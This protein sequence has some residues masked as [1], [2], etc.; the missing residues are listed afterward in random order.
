MRCNGGVGAEIGKHDVRV[1]AEAVRRRRDLR[2]LARCEGKPQHA[3]SEAQRKES[4]FK[5]I[6]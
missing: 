2:L 1:Q 3:A 5:A 4:G 6:V